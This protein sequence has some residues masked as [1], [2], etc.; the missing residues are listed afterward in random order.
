[1]IT[2]MGIR[3]MSIRDQVCPLRLCVFLS[4]F[5]VSLVN[6][7]WMETVRLLIR[8][9]GVGNSIVGNIMIRVVIGIPSIIGTVKGVN[10]FSF[11]WCFKEFV[12]L[13]FW[14]VLVWGR[15]SGNVLRFLV[16]IV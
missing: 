15:G 13:V 5:D 2:N 8:Q 6:H 14:C 12:V 3:K 11:M 9:F 10:R 16:E 1:M 4:C 7:C